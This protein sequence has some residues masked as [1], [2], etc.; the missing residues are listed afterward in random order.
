MDREKLLEQIEVNQL[1]GM[2]YQFLI[3][4]L[5]VLNNKSFEDVQKVVNQLLFERKIDAVNVPAEVINPQLKNQET[6]KES[7]L[8]YMKFAKK[9]NKQQYREQLVE[10]DIDR[11][12]KMLERKKK[13]KR[14]YRLDGKI[15]STS[16]GY[17]FLIPTNPNETDVYIAEK[18]LKGALNNDLV[19]VDVSFGKNGKPEGK[20]IQILERAN[21]NIVGKITINKGGA[22]VEPD[23]V[24]FGKDIFIPLSQ[25]NGASNG[26]KVTVRIERYFSG[27]K[28]PEGIVLED[29]G[30]PNKIETEVLAILR[31]NKLYDDFP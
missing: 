29:L 26:H 25:L 2:D 13:S 20:V 17:A 11:A 24:K 22:Y 9:K 5:C 19:A 23:D 16:K 3:S 8:D 27:K 4:Q 21:D 31:A 7:K 6:N 10:D 12:Y 14:N 18:N 15:Q 30:E 1:S 28:A